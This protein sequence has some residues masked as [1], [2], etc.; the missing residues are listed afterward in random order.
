[1]SITPTTREQREVVI[2]YLTNLDH[3]EL[4]SIRTDYENYKN[5]MSTET[6]TKIASMSL[7]L[8]RDRMNVTVRSNSPVS[9]LYEDLVTEFLQS[10]EMFYRFETDD[11]YYLCV[12]LMQ[13]IEDIGFFMMNALG[14]K[15]DDRHE[16]E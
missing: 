13:Q 9:L 16:I 11:H 3:D 12:M 8:K 6:V 1:M 15:G 7:Y 10:Y 5:G 2:K 14:I 4:T